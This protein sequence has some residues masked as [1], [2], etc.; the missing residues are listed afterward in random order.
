MLDDPSWFVPF[1][2][3]MTSEKLPWRATPAIHGFEKWP[4]F[5]EYKMLTEEY[6]KLAG[7][8]GT[9]EKKVQQ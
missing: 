5:A 1:I 4:S 6:A 3:T 8:V 9:Q 7:R 2:E